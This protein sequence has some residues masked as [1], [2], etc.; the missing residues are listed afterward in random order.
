MDMRIENILTEYSIII[1][2]RRIIL[3]QND[4]VFKIKSFKK[5]SAYKYPQD[6]V[7]AV[8]LN[9]SSYLKCTTQFSVT[10]LSIA[11]V[12]D[13]PDSGFTVST[14]SQR[15]VI[16]FA[17]PTVQVNTVRSQSPS[18]ILSTS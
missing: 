17:P 10:A 12:T 11:S 3:F 2:T 6:I 13:S 1:T 18:S 15:T 7:Y 4:H 16:L 14:Y 8:I 9:S 5:E